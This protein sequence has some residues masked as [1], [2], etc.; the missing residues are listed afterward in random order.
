MAM[1][2]VYIDAA[3]IPSGSDV[4]TSLAVDEAARALAYLVDASI[5]IVLVGALDDVPVAVRS[6]FAGV[7]DDATGDPTRTSWLL[8]GDPARCGRPTPHVRTILV[9]VVTEGPA[10]PVHR[11]DRVVRDLRTAVLEVLA[12]DAMPPRASAHH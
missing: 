1:T 2:T 11:C 10:R 9:G 4:A 12:N 3:A 6:A 5:G 8:T 7:V